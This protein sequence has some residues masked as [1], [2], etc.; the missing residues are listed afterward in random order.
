MIE[1]GRCS[2]ANAPDLVASHTAFVTKSSHPFSGSP[3]DF[4]GVVGVDL[5]G[6]IL[7]A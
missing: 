1:R 3:S 6:S 7:S 5:V 4:A 2:A